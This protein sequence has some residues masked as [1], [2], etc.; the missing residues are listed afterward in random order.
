MQKN[1]KNKNPHNYCHKINKIWKYSMFKIRTT[2]NK[3]KI[4][5]KQ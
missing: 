2:H 5:N 1:N 3:N 4:K